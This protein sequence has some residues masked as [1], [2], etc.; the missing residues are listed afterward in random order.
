MS[1]CHFKDMCI[2]ES[3]QRSSLP[4]QAS[5]KTKDRMSVCHFQE[6]CIKESAQRSP[7]LKQVSNTNKGSYEHPPLSRSVHKGIS[8]M[9]VA[10]KASEQHKQRIV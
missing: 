8:S 6:V 7:L 5:N 2:K 4:K 9:I 1:V 3:V 10:S